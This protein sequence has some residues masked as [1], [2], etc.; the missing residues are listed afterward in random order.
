MGKESKNKTE[1]WWGPKKIELSNVHTLAKLHRFLL[2]F[3]ST[4]TYTHI[5]IHTHT[6]LYAHILTYTYTHTFTYTY[7]YTHVHTHIHT[8]TPIHIHAY[9][10]RCPRSV[11]VKAMD[12]GIVSEF[13]LQSRYYVHYRSN[14]LE[15]G[16]NLIILPPSYG[17]NSTNTVLL[18][19]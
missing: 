12:C 5:L 7:I 10:G 3:F 6:Y 4:K 13:E 9:G 16:M 15:K 18:E 19:G 2:V 1:N 11:M 8:Y 14:T 17:F